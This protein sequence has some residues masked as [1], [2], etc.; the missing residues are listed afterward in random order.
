[1]K[2]YRSL[3]SALYARVAVHDRSGSAGLAN[4]VA[5]LRQRMAADGSPLDPQCAFVDDGYSGAN[6]Q[7]P[8]L[9]RLR[10]QAAQGGLDRLYVAAPDRLTRNAAHYFLLRDEFRRVGVDVIFVAANAPVS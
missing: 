9:Q 6:L 8:A 4:Q 5:A 7:R 1:M 2:T 10:Q 3:R